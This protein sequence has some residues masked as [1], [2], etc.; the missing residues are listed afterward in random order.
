MA[1]ILL[2]RNMAVIDLAAAGQAASD[3]DPRDGGGLARHIGR[4]RGHGV[5]RF[6]RDERG[7]T[8]PARLPPSGGGSDAH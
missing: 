3:A 8:L 5:P 2:E 4:L 6:A 1:L 7:R